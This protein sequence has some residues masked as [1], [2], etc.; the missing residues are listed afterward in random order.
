M[1]R[2]LENCLTFGISQLRG[3][4]QPVDLGVAAIAEQGGK[5]VLVRHSYK[6]GWLLPGGAVGRGEAPAEAVLR[7][8]QEEIGLTQSAKP[9]LLGLF[10]RRRAFYATNVIAL[11]RVREAVFVFKPNFEIRAVR[12]ADPA[13]PPEGTS[14]AVRR[15]LAELMGEAP[16]HP[17]W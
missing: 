2:F 8:L 5:V 12:L 9:Q 14:P 3:L 7:E 4:L 11:Y 10:T 13:S 6:S 16:Q 1:R 15:R 17:Y